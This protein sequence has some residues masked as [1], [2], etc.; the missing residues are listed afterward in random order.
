MRKLQSR[1]PL[2]SELH[3]GPPQGGY[4]GDSTAGTERARVGWTLCPALIQGPGGTHLGHHC[5]GAEGSWAE[6]GG[7]GATP[8]PSLWS[9]SW[10]LRSALWGARSQG[11]TSESWGARRLGGPRELRP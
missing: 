8:P 1:G 5:T 3:K 7:E 4:E 10:Q 2:G 11:R 9:G 6:P